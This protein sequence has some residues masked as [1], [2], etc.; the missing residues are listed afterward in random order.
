MTTERFGGSDTVQPLF[1]R[2]NATIPLDVETRADS[3]ESTGLPFTPVP[4]TPF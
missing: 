4:S 1:K 2:M 3:I